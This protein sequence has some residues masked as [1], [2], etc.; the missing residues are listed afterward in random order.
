MTLCSIE[1]NLG[2][3]SLAMLAS[4]F[5]SETTSAP[6]LSGTLGVRR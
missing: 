2:D 6:D 4:D 3:V 1:S 5:E